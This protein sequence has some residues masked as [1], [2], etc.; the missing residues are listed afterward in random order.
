MSFIKNPGSIVVL[1]PFYTDVFYHY[2]TYV[3]LDEDQGLNV[4]YNLHLHSGID[5]CFIA[6]CPYPSYHIQEF[7]ILLKPQPSFCYGCGILWQYG[8]YNMFVNY[9]QELIVTKDAPPDFFL[10]Q[11]ET[12][13]EKDYWIM[14]HRAW[15]GTVDEETLICAHHKDP[16][17]NITVVKK[18]PRWVR[19]LSANE[20]SHRL[21]QPCGYYDPVDGA[22]GVLRIGIPVNTNKLYDG[23]ESTVITYLGEAMTWKQ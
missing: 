23:K 16:S 13:Q 14:D 21:N 20:T 19:R 7:D 4:Y 6:T 1:N 5:E 3:G 9:K 8:K 12:L 2:Q 10:E 11:D 18:F 22:E 17:E 15:A